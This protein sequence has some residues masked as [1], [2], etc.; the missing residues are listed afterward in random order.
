MSNSL[1]K[2][3]LAAG[4]F[5]LVVGV[6]LSVKSNLIGTMQ[7]GLNGATENALIFV[8]IGIVCLVSGWSLRR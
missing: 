2:S 7:Q 1:A 3:I 5:F 8:I 6:L 4:V